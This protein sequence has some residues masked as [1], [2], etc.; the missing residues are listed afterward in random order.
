[1]KMFG[2]SMD[3]NKVLSVGNTLYTTDDSELMIRENMKKKDA[4]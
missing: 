2:L 1:M 3:R 4:P